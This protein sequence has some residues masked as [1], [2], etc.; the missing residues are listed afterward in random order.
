MNLARGGGAEALADDRDRDRGACGFLVAGA[1]VGLDADAA[2]VGFA[3]GR[4]VGGL[5]SDSAVAPV[6]A[7]VSSPPVAPVA[8]AV[9][10]PEVVSSSSPQP[11]IAKLARTTARIASNI[12][13]RDFDEWD[14]LIADL[15]NADI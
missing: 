1:A 4:G 3:G 7:V 8:A 2:I 9:A 14:M 15:R 5:S 12:E 10:P 13:I 11:A 6:T